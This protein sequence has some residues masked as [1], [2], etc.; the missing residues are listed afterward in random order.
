MVLASAPGKVILFGEHAVVYGEPALAGA[1]EKRVYV[2]AELRKDEKIKIF[3]ESINRGEML[4]CEKIT[5]GAEDDLRYVK[6]AIELTFQHLKQKSGIDIKICSE[7]PPA[8]GLGSS[9]AVSVSTILAVSKLLGKNLSKKEIASLGH[10]VELQVQGAASPTDTATATYGGVLFLQ[11]RK[12]VFTQVKHGAIP[13]V[14]GCTG[15][16]RS[17]GTL[18]RGVRELRG[19]NPEIVDPI[20]K[21]IGRIAREAKK[22]VERNED[23]GE[24]MNLNHGLLEALGVGSEKLARLVYAARSAG[25]SGAKITGAGGG[26]CMIAYAPRSAEKIAKAIE[27]C[28]CAALRARIAREGARVEK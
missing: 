3:S 18:V 23:L 14:I 19:R 9:A 16:A 13:L 11:P 27:G 21:N 22:A 7:L 17:T 8:S 6:K 26:G 12:K 20:I 2:E 25:A 24:L 15:D 5:I 28:G 1:I 10:A 4:H